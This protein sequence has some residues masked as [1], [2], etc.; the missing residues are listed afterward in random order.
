[1]FTVTSSNAPFHNSV[2]LLIY[3]LRGGF[4][5]HLTN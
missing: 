4:V 5:L 3:F 2:A 1:V